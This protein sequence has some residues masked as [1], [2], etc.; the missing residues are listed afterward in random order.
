MKNLMNGT[1]SVYVIVSLL[2]LS[3][4]VSVCGAEDNQS[5]QYDRLFNFSNLQVD[6]DS[7]AEW[8]ELN[9]P[10]AIYAVDEG[11]PAIPSVVVSLPMDHGQRVKSVQL[12]IISQVVRNLPLPVM[13]F[14]IDQSPESNIIVPGTPNEL[15]Y[16]KTDFLPREQVVYKI[17]STLSSGKQLAII[18]IN[19]VSYS[20]AANQLIC[21]HDAKLVVQFETGA[22]KAEKSLKSLRAA[23]PSRQEARGKNSSR[24]AIVLMEQ[25]FAPTEIPSIDGSRVEYIIISPPDEDMVDE[26]QRLADWKTDSGHPAQVVTTEWI[27]EE[28]SHG[29]DLPE[30]IRY[31]LRDAYLHWGLKEVVLGADVTLVPTRYAGWSHDQAYPTDFYYMCLEGTWDANGDGRFVEIAASE[32]NSSDFTQE[33]QVGRVSAKTATQ[34]TDWLAK[35]FVYVQSPALDGY[36]DR[37]LMLGEVLFSSQWSLTGRNGSP[38]CDECLV[39]G[40]REVDGRDVCVTRDGANDC[41]FIADNLWA[42]RGDETPDIKFIYERDYIHIPAYPDLDIEGP[43]SSS[44]TVAAISDGYHSVLHVGHADKDRWAVGTGRLLI[45]QLGTFTNG[46]SNHY[47]YIVGVDCSSA[48]LNYDSIGESM[49]MLPGHGGVSYVGATKSAMAGAGRLFASNFYV[50]LYTGKGN[51]LGDGYM[52]ATELYGGS[53]QLIYTRALIGDPGMMVWWETPTEMTLS[54]DQSPPIGASILPVTVTGEDSNPIEGAYVCVHKTGDVYAVGYTGADGIVEIPFWASS[55][56]EFKVTA[57]SDENIPVTNIGNVSDGSDSAAL[58]ITNFAMIDDGQNDSIGNSN[59]LIDLGE[60]IRIGLELHNAGSAAANG[61]TATLELEASAP[62]GLVDITDDDANLATISPEGTVLT[63]FAFL[64]EINSTPDEELFGETDQL[65]VPFNLTLNYN[66]TET[67]VQTIYLDVNRP[68]LDVG[69]NT[70]EEVSESQVKFWFGVANTGKGLASN[71]QMNVLGATGNANVLY[72]SPE[73]MD[74]QDIAPGDTVYAGPFDIGFGDDALAEVELTVI[75]TFRDSNPALHSRLVKLVGPI[76]PENVAAVGFPDAVSLTW[77]LNELIG[78]DD[79]GGYKIYRADDGATEFEETHPGALKDHT[80]ATDSGLAGLTNY[81]YHVRMMD[82]GGNL[83]E[84]SSVITVSTSPPVSSGWPN[85]PGTVFSASPTVAETDRLT[86]PYGGRNMREIFFAGEKVYGFHGDGSEITDGDNVGS[87]TGIFSSEGSE[88]L[89]KIA[90]GDLDRA[91]GEWPEI[92][93][94]DRTSKTLFCWDNFGN[95]P[96]WSVQPPYSTAWNTPVIADLDKD[97]YPEVILVAGENE[98]NGIYAFKHDSTPF[99]AGSVNGLL[100]NLGESYCYNSLA[101]G[102]IDGNEWPDIAV[103]GRSGK[104]HVVG[105]RTGSYLAG[106]EGGI[107]LDSQCRSSI[108]IAEVNG[109]SGDELFVVTLNSIYCFSDNGLKLWQTSFE[110]PYPNSASWDLNSE[111]ALGDVDGDDYIDLV[112]VDGGNKLM[113]LDARH[114]TMISH[115]PVSLEEGV[116]YGSCILANIDDEPHP[117]IIFGD[118]SARIHAYTYRGEKAPGF[119]IYY[120]G[121]LSVGSLAAGDVDDDGYQN[122]IVSSRDVSTLTVFDMSNSPYDPYSVAENPWPQRRCNAFNTGYFSATDPQPAIQVVLEETQVDNQGR[123]TLSWHSD[124]PRLSFQITRRLENSIEPAEVIVEVA[125]NSN[126]GESYYEITD[127]PTVAGRYLYAIIQIGSDGQQE[128][129]PSVTIDVNRVNPFVLSF[130]SIGPQPVVGS[131]GCRIN[132]TLPGIGSSEIP[133]SIHVFDLQGR[134]VGVVTEEMFT[135][136]DQSIEWDGR[137]QSGHALETGMYLLRLDTMGRSV[138]RRV[139][140]IQ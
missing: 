49:V 36:L 1:I 20:A 90:V 96:L 108:S 10:G 71:L 26:W 128:S 15:A 133:A 86:T 116:H 124:N 32:H 52:G 127:R 98:S 118:G 46:N 66:S 21:V 30:Q 33:I 114:G 121:N 107:E 9:L 2:F 136:G 41:K 137:G 18:K 104:L 134:Q 72:V 105:G 81:Q 138:H 11:D 109:Y 88:F 78:S 75:D 95:S 14:T 87:T 122:L 80:Y 125:A 6:L 70:R 24:G 113:A 7:S 100:A 82:A 112:I 61:V 123:V 132:F 12:E 85:D 28:Y 48:A 34:I 29:V 94:L 35:Y 37:S 99:S 92:V 65:A 115:F 64:L 47:S 56:G 5:W 84:A 38:D 42:A 126:P 101:V 22:E 40:C 60:T 44:G 79:V 25:G 111:P 135:P 97:S 53:D 83:G 91:E 50:S 62:A 103:A 39:E 16:A 27:A 3:V 89:G 13:P 119:P 68:R 73:E 59:S 54:F 139:M 43:L 23:L 93:G 4:L 8:I 77:E 63:S 17:S 140:L 106:Y 117:E 19:P 58:I 69:F 130:R 120:S 57:T 102:D 55:D 131:R 129:G 76:A 51:T 110:T 74:L 67:L 45:N 31:F